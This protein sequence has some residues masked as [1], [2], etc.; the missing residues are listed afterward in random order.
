[1]EKQGFEGVRVLVVEDELLVALNLET[2]LL[3]SG[4][5]V[6]G[7]IGSLTAALQASENETPDLAILDIN[8]RGEHVYPVAERLQNQGIPLIFCSGY[9]DVDTLPPAFRGCVKLGKPYGVREVREAMRRVLGERK[10]DLIPAE[11]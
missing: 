1:M 6:I 2:F 5:E 3:E 4:C 9:T 7:P 11:S 8:L 10:P